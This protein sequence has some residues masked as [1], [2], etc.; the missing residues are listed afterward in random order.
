MP[1]PGTRHRCPAG[2]LRSIAAAMPGRD[3]RLTVLLTHGGLDISINH[4]ARRLGPDAIAAL[5]QIA[6]A[7][8]LARITVNGE[9]VI[10]RAAPTLSFGGVECRAAAR[11]LRAGG[12]K[13]RS[14]KSAGWCVD[15]VGRV[16]ARGRSVLRHRDVHPAARAPEPRAGR[17]RRPG[18]HRRPRC[19]RPACTRAQADRDET[20]R[21]V[22][23][24]TFGAGAEGFRRGRVRSAA[25]RRQGAGRTAGAIAGAAGGRGVLRSGNAWRATCAFSSTAA[26]ASKP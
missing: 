6:A 16:Q 21:S 13:R 1:D 3:I 11:R 8:R 7:H 4:G 9:T 22:P 14:W 19:R 26:T 18:R 20:A 2:A 17:R 24:A 10:E 5:A 25:R 12:G 15:A 23:R